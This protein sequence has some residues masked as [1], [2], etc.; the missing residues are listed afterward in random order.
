MDQVVDA[1][2]NLRLAMMPLYG[3]MSSSGRLMALSEE[4]KQPGLEMKLE[5]AGVEQFLTMLE[6]TCLN[7][8]QATELAQRLRLVNEN[9]SKH[10]SLRKGWLVTVGWVVLH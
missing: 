7:M 9:S 5:N 3:A 1:D 8:R 10:R 6:R 2:S 4:S